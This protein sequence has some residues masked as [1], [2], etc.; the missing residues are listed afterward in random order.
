MSK[1]KITDYYALLEVRPDASNMDIINAYRRAKLTYK[2]DSMATY[3][4]FDDAE[5]DQIRAEIEQ[6]YQTLSNP[7]RRRD[8]DTE[9]AA[10]SPSGIRSGDAGHSPADSATS[11]DNIVDLATKAQASGGIRLRM[12]T[13]TAYPGAL[14]KEIREYR[15]VALA[16]IA[17][18]TKISSR[19]LQAIE[20]EDSRHLPEP[21]YLKGYLKQYAAEIGLDPERVASHYPPL[22]PEGS[23]SG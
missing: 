6:A 2:A 14:L 15:G 18:R 16:A 23:E 17:E 1:N 21:T 7:E 19:Y 10:G 13:A 5:L 9:L 8:Y 12:A 4:L 22:Q 11:H 20:E 3:A